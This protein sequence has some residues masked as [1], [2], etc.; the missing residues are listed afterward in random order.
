MPWHFHCYQT[1]IPSVSVGQSRCP[2]M[3]R[4]E[5]HGQNGSVYCS[6]LWPTCW[7]VYLQINVWLWWCHQMETFSSLLALCE[8]NP[9]VTRGQWHRTLMFTFISAWANGWANN[10][11]A[12]DSRLHRA[13]YDF[14]VMIMWSL[15]QWQH[16]MDYFGLPDGSKC[17][18]NIPKCEI[19]NVFCAFKVC[20]VFY[21]Y[22]RHCNVIL[23][24][25]L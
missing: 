17:I 20:S 5:Q 14:T 25:I 10:L 19:Y 2:I 24:V 22:L 12:G 16:V 3:P 9:L 13:H 8:G 11:D 18:S 15:V 4:I 7:E 1:N 23:N 21:M 6:C